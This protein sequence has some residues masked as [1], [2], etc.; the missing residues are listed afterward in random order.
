MDLAR[1]RVAAAGGHRERRPAVARHLDA[2]TAHRFDRDAYVRLRN[3]IAFHLYGGLAAGER[4]RDQQP[5]EKLARDLAAH[6][7]A[8]AA[9][10]RRR[11]N[12][13]RRVARLAEEIDARTQVLQRR[14]EVADRAL[15]H[16][17]NA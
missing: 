6:A 8:A 2:E 5:G 16:A 7:Y 1:A 11:V 14:D 15:V 9:T 13:K 12:G 10:D 4:Q 17:G 3:E